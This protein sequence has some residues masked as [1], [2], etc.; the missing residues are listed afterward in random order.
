MVKFAKISKYLSEVA[1]NCSQLQLC[2][3]PEDEYFSIPLYFH[4]V[5]GYYLFFDPW[6]GLELKDM[7]DY[8]FVE[9]HE[10]SIKTEK[11]LW[12]KHRWTC[13]LENN[14][15]HEK[16]LNEFLDEFGPIDSK[17]S[18]NYWDYNIGKCR[19]EHARNGFCHEISR[20]LKGG[21]EE[22]MIPIIYVP[23]IH[24]Y[25][26]LNKKEYGGF[27]P[28]NYCP[29]CGAKYFI[30]SLN[31][32]SIEMLQ[33]ECNLNYCRDYENKLHDWHG[34]EWIRE[35]KSEGQYIYGFDRV[36]A[37]KGRCLEKYRKIKNNW[38]KA[39]AKCSSE[40][41]VEIPESTFKLIKRSFIKW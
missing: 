24:G 37:L 15:L 19:D 17:N 4:G 25:A 34:D 2:Y 29:F 14:K 31:D 26:I 35:L 33:L 36:P 13:F 10:E 6:T 40:T 38:W 11:K 16:E 32:I 7:Y 21:D 5:E 18:K 30:K 3:D 12:K 41:L 1:N 22:Y 28:M 39:C 8:E 9:S 23:D 27:E 20:F